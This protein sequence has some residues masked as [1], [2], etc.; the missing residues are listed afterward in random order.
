M[1]SFLLMRL[2]AFVFKSFHGSSNVFV[3]VS[4]RLS[5]L[6]GKHFEI[7]VKMRDVNER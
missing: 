2:S 7:F 4:V 6:I 3:V 5:F 1:I